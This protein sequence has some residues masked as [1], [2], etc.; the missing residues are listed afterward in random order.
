MDLGKFTGQVVYDA[1]QDLY[2]LELRGVRL[3]F[4]TNPIEATEVKLVAP[5][6]TDKDKNSTLLLGLLGKNVHQAIL[7][8]NPD[9]AMELAPEISDIQ[10][11]VQMVNPK[12][13]G[14]VVYTQ[15]ND[16]RIAVRS[17]EDATSRK[18]IVQIKGPESGAEATRVSVLGT[19]QFV[20]EG[21]TSKKSTRQ[22]TSYRSR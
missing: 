3:P 12:K 15:S 6:K 21:K 8:I 2:F 22:R 13:F 16:E 7:L 14:G 11:Y 5:G 4:K 19:G 20:I 1:T 9:E 10:R 17:L 18:P